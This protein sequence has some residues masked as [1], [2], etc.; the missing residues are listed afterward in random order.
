MIDA[1]YRRLGDNPG[2]IPSRNAKGLEGIFL[3]PVSLK[4]F[5]S[6]PTL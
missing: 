3:G 2:K 4:L 5:G 6:F 1:G